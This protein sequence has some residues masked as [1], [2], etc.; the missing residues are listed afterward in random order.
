MRGRLLILIAV[1]RSVEL[2]LELERRTEHDMDEGKVGG[3]YN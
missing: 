3:R 2:E 1:G